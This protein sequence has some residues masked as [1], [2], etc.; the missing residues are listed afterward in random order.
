MVKSGWVNERWSRKGNHTSHTARVTNK[1]NQP[2]NQPAL[3]S[4]RRV[5][6]ILRKPNPA[7]DT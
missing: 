2:T 3:L 1:T 6:L 7:N 5:F 4:I